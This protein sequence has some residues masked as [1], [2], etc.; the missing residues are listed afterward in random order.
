MNWQALHL[1]NEDGTPK[2][3]Y[4]INTGSS[5]SSKTW[6]IMEVI[7]RYC[8]TNE[9]TR[10]TAW[11]NTKTDCKKTVWKDW[12]KMLSLSNR[13]DYAK[14]NK[15]EAI[16]SF[17]ENTTFEIHGTDDEETVHGLTQNLAW[18]N[19]P[20][21]ISR[22]TFDQIDQRAD[23][24]IIDWNPK[25]SHW[26]EEVS[27]LPNAIVIDS[28]FEDNPF[29]PPE[30]RNKILSYETLPKEYNYLK[31]LGQEDANDTID[32]LSISDY[33]KFHLK[34]A[35]KNEH[36]GTA[37]AYMWSVYGKGLKAEKPNRIYRWTKIKDAEYFALDRPV[38]YLVDWGAVHPMGILEMKY[39]DGAV[40]FHEINYKS[41]NE[42]K[43]DLTPTE[44]R[45]INRSVDEGFITWFFNKL[46]IPYDR[47][48][49][50]DNNRPQKI[51]A[52]REVGYDYA[53][54][55]RKFPGSVLDGIDLLSNIQVYFTESSTNLDYEQE[56]YSR[57]VDNRTGEVLEE[58]EDE[59]N[60]LT[61]PASYGVRYLVDEGVITKI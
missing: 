31:E 13:M 10:A 40:Y 27:K 6:S 61:D 47:P 58:P 17:N 39:Y 44:R 16:Y 30:Q 24:V 54:A 4:I 26:V 9:G 23:R 15:T 55:C 32:K 18:L 51:R 22:Y 37:D 45:Q 14:R 59:N 1:T 33:D 19:E 12:Q 8:Q 2:Y 34:N 57:K 49:V 38:Y 20:Y 41:E 25:K 52:L 48:I 60:H 3:K 29:C 46:G 21:K 11:R 35:W 50:C 5:R 42:I 53:I 7:Y 43:A 28:T 36:Y 56:N